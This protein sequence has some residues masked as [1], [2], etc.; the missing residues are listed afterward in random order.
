MTEE[1][2]MEKKRGFEFYESLGN[3]VNIVAPM[4]DASELG[5]ILLICN[6]SKLININA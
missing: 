5:K 6:N 1:E 4:V 2:K 3:P